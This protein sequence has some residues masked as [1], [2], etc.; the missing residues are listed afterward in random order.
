MKTIT[1]YVVALLCLLATKMNAQTF[2]DRAAQIAQN[3]EKV[4]K[5]QKDSLKVEIEGV[6]LLLDHNEITNTE[7]DKRKKEFA[8]KRAANIEAMVA[9][10]QD[11]LNQLVNDRVDGKVSNERKT[12]IGSITITTRED[13]DSI[14]VVRVQGDRRTTSQFVFAIGVN[15]LLTDGKMDE[16]NFEWRS[17][18]YEWGVSFNSRLAENN[19]LL[20]LKYG[21]SLQYNNLRPNN[22]QIFVNRDGQTVL[23]YSG[24]EN[25][26][27]ARLRY[28][29]LVVPMHLEFD[30]TKKKVVD[31]KTYFPSHKSFR[32]GIG[33][34]VGVNVKEKQIIK[35]ENEDG[36]DVKEK[37]KGD[38]NLSEFVYGVS[39]Y[40]GYKEVSLYAKYDLQP[41]FSNNAVDQNTLSLGV[42]FDLN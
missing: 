20:H 42:R 35:Y 34:Y 30:F 21:L 11:K 15:R 8:E 14:K 2:G 40:V 16:G 37:R 17:D 31:G 18:Y 41:T 38:Y 1:F 33:G 4:T 9:V 28:V 6:N 13:N 7:A 36:Q 10:E 32:A 29:N 27:V 24:R 26:D 19:N 5:E 23:E 39:A 22:N 3:I 12:Q 25:I